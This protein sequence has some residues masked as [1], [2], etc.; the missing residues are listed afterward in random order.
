MSLLPPGF[1]DLEVFVEHWDVPTTNE[2]WNRRAGTPIEDIRSFYEAMLGRADE[3]LRH[4]EQYPL[5]GMPADAARLS[6]LLMALAHAATA[7]EMHRASR[8]PHSPFPHMLSVERGFAP[9][10]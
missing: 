1:E 9:Y 2:R 8:V 5:D 10:G 3:A 7:V 6:R 4:C